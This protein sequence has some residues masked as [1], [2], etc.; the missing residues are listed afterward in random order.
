MSDFDFD[1][2]FVNNDDM[3]FIFKL[4]LIYLMKNMFILLFPHSNQI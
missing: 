3:H 1:K 2:F 4:F